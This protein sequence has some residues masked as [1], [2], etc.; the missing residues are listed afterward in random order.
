MTDYNPIPDANLD[1]NTPA[2][3]IDAKRLRDNP[4]AMFEGA[5]GAPR[6]Q[7]G[8]INDSAVTEDKIDDDAVTDDK[9]V[10]TFLADRLG[11]SGFPVGTMSFVSS[12][13]ETLV[14]IG[15]ILD[16]DINSISLGIDNNG[17]YD[18]LAVTSSV[19]LS[20]DW[21]AITRGVKGSSDKAFFLAIRVA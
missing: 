14:E 21:Q 9:I 15:D 18:S 2:R 5:V 16:G 11:V 17:T 10:D 13:V 1:P 4:L 3:S 12:N 20:G 8:G 6:L 7:T 19:A